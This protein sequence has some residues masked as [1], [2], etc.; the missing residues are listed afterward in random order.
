MQTRSTLARLINSKATFLGLST[1]AVLAVAG[2][3]F[4]YSAMSHDVTVSVD[5]QQR[6]V[7]AMG[8]TVGDVLESE[9]IEVDDRDVVAPGLDEEVTDGSAISVRFARQLELTVDGNTTTHWVTATDVSGALSQLGSRFAGAD[10]S[11]SRGGSIDREG[12]SLEV[13]TEKTL[14]VKVA[15]QKVVTRK[16]PAL[17]ARGALKEMGVKVDRHDR[18]TPGPDRELDDGDKVVLT[19]IDVKTKRVQDEAIDFST[20]EREDSSMLEGKTDT[21]RSGK[22]GARDVTYRQTFRNG[23]LVTTKVLRQEVLREPVDA[24][25]A[26]G[27]KEPAPEPVATSNYASGSTVWDQLAQCESGGNWAINTGNG[28]YGGLQFNLGTWQSYGGPGYPHEQSRETQIAIA[29]KVRAATGGYGS[30]PACSASLG[31]PQ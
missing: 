16:I 18:I 23:E 29:E 22:A 25:V 30:W 20:V 4:G 11:V 9:G 24:I 8:G 19:D 3:T 17:T 31:L 12:M 21:V 6:E 2:T 5:G 14:D 1:A 7:S 10:L 27:T 26:V 15:D 13:V 28:Y